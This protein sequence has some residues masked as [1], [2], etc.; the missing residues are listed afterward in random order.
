M[1]IR[2]ILPAA[3]LA[4]AKPAYCQPVYSPPPEPAEVALLNLDSSTAFPKVNANDFNKM[5]DLYN[6]VVKPYQDDLA[7]NAPGQPSGLLAAVNGATVTLS[8]SNASK[9]QTAVYV[10][11]GGQVIATLAGNAVTAT[12]SPGGGTWA[13]S[14]T[15]G[16]RVGNQYNYPPFGVAPTVTATVAGAPPVPSVG[17]TDISLVP[18]AVA[19]YVSASSGSDANAGTISAPLM[20]L[21]AGYSKLRDGQPDQLLLKCGDTFSI[22]TQSWTKA[23]GDPTKPMIVA[24]YGTGARPKIR[25][26]GTAFYGGSQNKRGLLFADLDL[27]PNSPTDGSSAFLFFTPWSNIRIEGCYIVGYAVNIVMQEVTTGVRATGN[28]VHRCVF[29]DSNSPGQ[30]HSQNIFIGNQDGWS[31][32]E[33]VLDKGGALEFTIFSHNLYGSETNGTLTVDGNTFS[34]AG[35][36]AYQVR[37]GGRVVRNLSL[38]NPINGYVGDSAGQPSTFTDNVAIDSRDVNSIDRR[39][40]GFV[41]NGTITMERNVVAH[42]KSGTDAIYGYNLNGVRGGSFVSNV[43]YDWGLAANNFGW[44]S[45]VQWDGGGSEPFLF[46]NNII[47]QKAG[48]YGVCVRNEGTGLGRVTYRNNKYFTANPFTG[49]GQFQ[50]AA[51][52]A[53]NTFTAWKAVAGEAGSTFAV[54]PVVDVSVGAYLTS[55]GVTPGS[56]PLVTYITEA[57]KQSKANWRAAY[58]AE[59]YVRFAQAKFGIAPAP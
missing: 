30:G 19:T 57:R 14:V 45:L 59:A 49:Y 15:T 50:S 10:L 24:S 46:E 28:S 13:Y 53:V 54:Q 33:S 25:S 44:P 52:N 3:V 31:L 7:A 8:W 47:A 6:A 26:N 21:S 40:F 41:V 29:G 1:L 9:P 12:D 55:I 39:G 18:G 20:T 38:Q 35:S 51:G 43:C 37:S 2:L 16:N 4:L 58:T 42:Q 34:R 48:Q 32:T 5:T 56:D 27:A 17:W 11:R 23:S 36:H 22:D